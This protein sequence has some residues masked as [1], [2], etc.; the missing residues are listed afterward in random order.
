MPASWLH[1]IDD[2]TCDLINNDALESWWEAD[3]LQTTGSLTLHDK[4][5][6]IAIIGVM[7]GDTNAVSVLEMAHRR[8]LVNAGVHRFDSLLLLER[9]LPQGAEFW[10]VCIDELM[11]LNL[12][13][14][15]SARA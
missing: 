6:Q 15:P 8:Q 10:H 1:D 11:L 5:R 4:H 13:L 2:E 14:F 7:M 12:A 3:L 9:P